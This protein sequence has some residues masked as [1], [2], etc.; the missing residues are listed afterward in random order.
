MAFTTISAKHVK[1]IKTVLMLNTT[2][3]KYIYIY[4]SFSL[5]RLRIEGRA[6]FSCSVDALFHFD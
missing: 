1:K 3:R 4:I 2:E 6:I 5:S